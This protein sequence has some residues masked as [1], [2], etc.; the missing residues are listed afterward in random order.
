MIDHAF[1]LHSWCPICALCCFRFRPVRPTVFQVAIGTGL[2]I[3]MV[4]MMYKVFVLAILR[5]IRRPPWADGAIDAPGMGKSTR[6]GFTQLFFSLIWVYSNQN[7]VSIS[8]VIEASLVAVATSIS[9]TAFQ[10]FGGEV[11]EYQRLI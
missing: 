1:L 11:D 3:V 6:K 2:V 7:S 10:L 8:G 5:R 9:N 4:V